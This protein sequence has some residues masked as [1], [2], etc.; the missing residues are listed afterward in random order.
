[1]VVAV[2]V[3]AFVLVMVTGVLWIRS[4]LRGR[5]AQQALATSLQAQAEATAKAAALEARVAFLAPYEGVADAALE[6]RRVR[7]VA[8]AE[9]AAMRAEVAGERAARL[10]QAERE[11]DEAT[12]RAASQ[13][14]A[15]EAEA[16]SIRTRAQ[17]EADAVVSAARRDADQWRV[18]AEKMVS[19]AGLEA[20]RI[21]SEAERR[22]IEVAR[23]GLEARARMKEY[24][25]QARAIKNVIDGYGDRYLV[26]SMGL[27]DAL[28]DEFG[29]REGG[30]QLKQ[31]RARVREMVK[32][33]EAAACDY[34]EAYRKETAEDFVLDAF[35][36]KVDAIL[37]DVRDDNFGTL[38]QKIKDAFTLVNLNGQAF[39]NARIQPAYLEL[40]L[41]E[42]RWAVVV[43]ELKTQEREEQRRIKEQIREE[44]KA[45][46][47]YERAMKEAEKEEATLR[48]AM[49]K[50]RS[51][52]EKAGDA[53]KATY[54]A[55]LRALQEKL[56]EAEAKN[57]RALSMAQQTKAGHVY[58]ISNVGSFGEHVFKVGMTR[59]L[60][61][62]DRVRELGDASVP[63][64]FDV[65]AMIQSDD[66]P[67]LERALHRRFVR[68]QVN[69]VNARKEFFRVPLPELRAELERQGIAARWTMLAECR[70]WKETQAIE[71]AMAAGD[72]DTDRW[73]V[74]QEAD[75]D[76]ALAT[77]VEA[78]E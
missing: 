71:Q 41:Q 8:A 15:A 60:E 35:N 75:H 66:A 5:A 52:F 26:P 23:D 11:V 69:K 17:G 47:E 45:R 6:A 16:A 43:N 36:G 40:R 62:L 72:F 44:E 10:E 77:A 68:S 14:V 58:V 9:A 73:A 57:Q 38:A 49:E 25:E 39:R 19:Q 42:L 33:R 53:Q 46:K 63:F 76:R 3:V 54:E 4:V 65:H 30:E 31:A 59:R 56:T 55:Q 2:A 51:E 29:S 13:R 50:A 67:A 28:A 74:R 34:A 48:K 64:E 7:E 32:T 24:E 61:P 21:V 12:Q 1:M 20:N 70:D 18:S 27:L 78:S 37:A 22:A